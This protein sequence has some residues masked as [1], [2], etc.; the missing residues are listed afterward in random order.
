MRMITKNIVYGMI[1]CRM[2][3]CIYFAF[4]IFMKQHNS[5][6]SFNVKLLICS[7]FPIPLNN[8]RRCLYCEMS[9]KL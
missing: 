4:D 9:L 2:I 6:F 8:L 3:N 5:Y 1:A 7:Y